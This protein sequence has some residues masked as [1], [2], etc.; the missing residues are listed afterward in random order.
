MARDF[1]I[2][3]VSANIERRLA[4][5]PLRESFISLDY[6]RPWYRRSDQGELAG[7]PDLEAI[8][9]SYCAAALWG[10]PS[11]CSGWFADWEYDGPEGRAPVSRRIPPGYR[12]CGTE[13]GDRPG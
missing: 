1:G 12:A 2:E 11:F 13:V 5:T 9:Y 8:Y 10:R 3:G 6:A 7:E 4:R